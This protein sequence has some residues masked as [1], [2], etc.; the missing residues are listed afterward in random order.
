L[1]VID[2]Q[3][4]AIAALMRT[5]DVRLAAAPLVD[6]RRTNRDRRAARRFDLIDARRAFPEAGREYG[7]SATGA[8][9]DRRKRS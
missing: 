6:R 2:E 3:K 4:A 9:S 7:L 1:D 5:F 8:V